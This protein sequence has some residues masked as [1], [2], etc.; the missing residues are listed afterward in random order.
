MIP[1]LSVKQ[2]L[3][4]MR[5][6]KLRTFMTMGGV[7]WG[8]LAIVL[9]F[10]F[11]KGIHKQQMKSQRG[12]GENIAIVWPNITSKPWQGLPRGR[13]INFTEEDVALMKSRIGSINY[14]SPEYSKWGV[15]LKYG[16][17]EVIQ[18]II[19]V[20]PEFGEMRNLIPDSGG[21][22][23]NAYDIG[24]KR[25]V[26]FIGDELKKQLFGTD[27][28]IGKYIL[29]NNVPFQVIGVLKPKKQDS[30]YSGRDNNKGVIPSS[31]FQGMYS[32]RYLN[33]FVVQHKETSSMQSVKDEIYTLLGNK[34]RFDPSDKEALSIWDTTEG[35]K[36]LST[37][38]WAF[39][40]FLIGIGVAT[41]I[42]GGIGVSNIMN[43]VLEERTKEIGIKMALGA[44]KAMIKLQFVFETLLLTTV[45][46]LAGYLIGIGIIKIVP[47]FKFDDFI[48]IP[49]VDVLGTAVAVGVLGII[50]LI[51]GYFPARR[52][53]NLQPVQALK[54]Y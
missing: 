35:M 42:T 3:R 31:T 5:N 25:R 16:R 40:I 36:F 39:R 27:E 20:W 30:S 46:G 2:F 28:A 41:L 18:N 12:L 24:L 6:Q 11:G 8:T 7:L 44:K 53:A 17:N 4:D 1:L 33:D 50:G 47:L 34:Y 21:R 52:A 54:L 49:E 37:F 29:V 19:G 38:F 23:I 9:L 26:I 32:R 13:N 10:G 22:F 14:I 51:S 45:G 43:V 15:R 48:G